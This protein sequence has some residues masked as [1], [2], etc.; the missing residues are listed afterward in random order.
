[1]KKIIAPQLTPTAGF[2]TMCGERK[3]QETIA[4]CGR[5]NRAGQQSGRGGSGQARMRFENEE[6][7]GKR[8][9]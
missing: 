8:H 4:W 7:E 6:K 1:M 9:D 3:H 5:A 2:A